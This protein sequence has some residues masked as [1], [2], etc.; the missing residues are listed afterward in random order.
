MPVLHG[1]AVKV[2]LEPHEPPCVSI[3]LPTHR[4]RNGGQQDPLRLRNLIDESEERLGQLEL[5]ASEAQAVVR[6]ARDLLEDG[7]FWRRQQGGLAVFLSRGW[8]LV[9]L[10][11]FALPEL[12]VVSS[13]FHVRPLLEGLWPD[14]RFYVLALSKHGARLFAGSRFELA[15]VEVPDMPGG[16]QETERFIVPGGQLQGHSG[17]R[18]G[19]SREPVLHGHGGGDEPDADRVLEYFRQVDRA[20]AP[21][22]RG[23]SPLVLAAVDYLVPLYRQA[24]GGERVLE[25]AVAGSPEN[26][27]LQELHSRAWAIVERRVLADRA[28]QVDRYQELATKG[29]ASSDLNEIAAALRQARVE[30]LFIADGEIVWGQAADG[31]WRV[32]TEPRLG[33]EDLLDR[34]AA[35]A[36][37]TG[38]AVYSLPRDQLPAAEPHAAIM[39]F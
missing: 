26:V 35:N 20:I 39:R 8:H 27:P 4:V 2:L 5:R 13:R 31:E 15:A 38:G 23:S 12:L 34:A 28:V 21:R 16:M 18:T 33:D 14:E 3:F 19:G 1:D 7:Q 17:A 9:L 6:P 29:R 22:L 36:L 11:P 37:R 32:H 25:E 30:V 10:A 24:A